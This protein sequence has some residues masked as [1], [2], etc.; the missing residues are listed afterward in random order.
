[1]FF[2]VYLYFRSISQIE[3]YINPC[4]HLSNHLFLRTLSSGHSIEVEF[5]TDG[6]NGQNNEV[7]FLEHIEVMLDLS[8]ER[9]GVLYA[10]IE[11][12]SGACRYCSKTCMKSYND[13]PI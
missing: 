5:T 12:P 7:N 11:S 13:S 1:M 6:C 8:Y 9:R 4:L 3:A 10:E 2:V